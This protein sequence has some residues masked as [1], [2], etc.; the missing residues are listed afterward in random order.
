MTAKEQSGARLAC[1]TLVVLFCANVFNVGDRMLLGMVAEPVKSELG[2]SDTGLSLAN[3]FLFVLANLAASLFIARLV[4]RGNRKRILAAGI[5]AWSVA[6]AATGLAQ[7]FTTLAVARVGLG[8]GEAAAFPAAMSMIPDLFRPET[9]G[10]AIAVYQSSGMV[11]MVFGTV[12][13]GSLAASFGWRSM[14][15]ACGAAGMLLA[16]VTLLTVRE[17]VRAPSAHAPGHAYLSGL[18]AACR[19]ILAQPGFV[20][21]A[22]AF[23]TSAILGAVLGNW[24]PAFLQRS[25]AMPLDQVGLV[26]APAVGLGGVAGTLASGA[27][28][29]WLVGRR[30][31][32]AD[33]L[34]VPLFTLPLA[35]PFTAGFV[36]APTVAGAMA[37]AFVLSLLLGCAVAPCINYAITEAD[38]G[39][40]AVTSAVMLAATGL[41]GGALGPFMVGVISDSLASELG[42]ESLRYAIGAM[43]V[44]PL[45][46]TLFL[47]AA[48]R[49]SF[50]RGLRLRAA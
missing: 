11:G 28:A 16:L 39:D 48:M 33:M 45:L 47:V 50:E 8:L 34:R 46:A 1:W 30:G 5:A 4:D 14:F 19:R 44:T 36:L 49:Q 31:V 10:K 38:P 35:A 32:T 40:R 2:L 24:S 29:D 27:L 37:C 12:V 41:I 6:T 15:F 25:H 7:D 43:A 17:P 3:G 9:R 42:R 13:A 21:L 26:L 18:A 20:F 22:L 23:G